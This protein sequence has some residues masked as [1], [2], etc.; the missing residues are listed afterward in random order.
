MKTIKFV[1]N[2]V[3]SM[4]N[5]IESIKSADSTTHLKEYTSKAQ[6]YLECVGTV[7]YTLGNDE[8]D[9]L[10]AVAMSWKCKVYEVAWHRAEELGASKELVEKLKSICEGTREDCKEYQGI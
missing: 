7:I 9:D 3:N 1:S 8:G 10:E 6:G 2:M 5:Y 4:M